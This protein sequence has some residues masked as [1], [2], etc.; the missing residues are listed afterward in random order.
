MA[1][2][3]LYFLTTLV[4]QTLQRQ[5]TEKVA[6][7]QRPETLDLARLQAITSVFNSL[8]RLA[9]LLL[10]SL[11][12][13]VEK[14]YVLAVIKQATILKVC[15]IDKFPPQKITK[16]CGFISFARQIFR[17]IDFVYLG[18]FENLWQSIIRDRRYAKVFGLFCFF[19]LLWF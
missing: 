18:V 8:R 19:L 14:H 7:E 6:K 5:A 10:K 1:K 12:N 15:I 13:N 17:V 16:L 9:T 4:R 11:V 3:I 2:T